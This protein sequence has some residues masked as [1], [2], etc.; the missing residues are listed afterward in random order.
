MLLP[1]FTTIWEGKE[2]PKDWTEDIIVKI[3]KKGALNNCNNW[4]GITLLSI[5]SKI[6]AK[7]IVQRLSDAVDQQLRKVQ[8]GFPKGR[9]CAD[10]IFILRNIIEQCTE[11]QRQLYINF[12]DFEKAF[13]SIH[14]ESLWRILLAYGIP[15]EIV[16]LIESFYNN[17]TCK[18]GSSDH[19]FQV[20]IGVMQGCV[21]SALLFNIAI[22]WVMRRTIEDQSR[23]IRWTLFT[24]FEDLDFAD[25]LA[26]VSH[27]HQHIQEKTSRL[28]TY[29]QQIGLKT[30]QTK[31]D[32]MT[33]N[34]PNPH[35]CR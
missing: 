19:R 21:M 30:S 20:K 14:R 24:A 29:A 5:P 23:G 6:L 10:K 32:V 8:A 31:T 15:Q 4:R 16:L 17:F 7:I 22:D 12:V 9:G 25:D 27:T 1:L 35:R 2:I 3:L 18:V 34:I 33:L 26:L 11:W 13:D 28:S